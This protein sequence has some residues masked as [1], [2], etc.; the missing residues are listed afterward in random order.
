MVLELR[1]TSGADPSRIR[2]A[3]DTGRED[4]EAVRRMV[5]DAPAHSV[6]HGVGLG[7]LLMPAAKAFQEMTDD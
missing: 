2:A 4:A 5:E 7:A 6:P 1:V 3:V